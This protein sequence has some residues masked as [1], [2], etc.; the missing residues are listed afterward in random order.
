MIARLGS[1]LA[2]S[3]LLAGSYAICSA[4]SHDLRN[5]TPLAPGVNRG[6]VDNQANGPNYYY[7]YAGPGHVDIEYSFKE[8][9]VSGKPL[10]QPLGFDLYQENNK[11][12]IH[13]TVVSFDKL[14]KL[15]QP[16][17]LDARHKLLIRVISP[18][19][20]LRLGGYYEIEVTG[21]VTFEGKSN[22]A[23]IKPENTDRPAGPLVMAGGAN[24]G[25]SSGGDA[26]LYTPVGALTSVQE[27][28]TELR[29]TLAADSLFD[30][31]KATIRPD[32]KAA[33]DRVAQIIR[34]KSRGVVRIEGFTDSPGAADRNLSL[35]SARAESVGNW[36]VTQAGLPAAGLTM[37]GFGARLFAAPNAKPDG[38]DDPAGRQKN[39]RVE[40]VVQK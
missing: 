37:H 29:L 22:G 6:T 30:L 40:I 24:N 10:K 35:A 21:K 15:S 18:N 16:G 14:E 23:D 5:P 13:S 7:F 32:A 3:A 33:L 9:G 19:T 1:H 26:S 34:S 28:P 38:S 11:L 36:L 39:R 8:M 2:A 17:T 20:A 25:D 4:Q 27:S 12:L 31:G